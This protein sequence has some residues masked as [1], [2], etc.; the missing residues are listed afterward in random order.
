MSGA[1]FIQL[2]LLVSGRRIRLSDF[3]GLSE[4]ESGLF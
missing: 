4:I 2:A 3:A 1:V